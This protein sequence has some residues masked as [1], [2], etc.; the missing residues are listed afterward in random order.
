MAGPH[1]RN[2]PRKSRQVRNGCLPDITGAALMGNAAIQQL[3]LG[4]SSRGQLYR[5]LPDG[6]AAVQP[7]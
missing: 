6:A 1:A 2:S 4:I 5:V 7:G 3:K